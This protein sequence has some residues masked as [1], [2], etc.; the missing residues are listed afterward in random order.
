VSRRPR[1]LALA[2]YP[3]RSAATRFRMT[4][5]LP[6]LEER[7]WEVRFEPFVDDAFLRSFY[8]EGNRLR[9]AS[10]LATRSLRRLGSALG[11]SGFDAVFIQREAAFVGPAYTERILHSLKGL[12]IVFDFDDAIWHLDLQRSTH[13]VAARLLKDPGKC[14][15]TM[16]RAAS[17]IAGSSYLAERAHEVNANVHTVPTVVS[18]DE[19]TP[20][21]GRLEGELFNEK[22][23]RIGWVGSLSTAHQLELVEPALHRLRAEG[24]EFEVHVV[25]AGDDFALDTVAIEARPWRLREEIE[26]FQRIDIGLAPMH[27]API[28]QGKCGFKQLQYMSV[29]VPFVSSWVG[30]ARDFVMHG[31]NGL[32][33]ENAEDWY[34]HLKALLQSRELRARLSRSGRELVETRYCIERQGPRVA[35]C[36]DEVLGYARAS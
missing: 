31:D 28:Y 7:G 30:G 5:V 25:G 10:Y 32:V 34:Q 3:E 4:A 2:A 23:P 8:A 15:Y 26:A 18:A 29:G 21:P 22:V 24:Y 14:W 20:V 6:Y 36:F 13:P 1:L 33:A 35:Q 19:W 9:K 12:P 11:A 17:V 27:S 16:R